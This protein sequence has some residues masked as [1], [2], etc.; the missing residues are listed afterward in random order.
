[1]NI[2]KAVSGY[3]ETT[4]TGTAGEELTK[5]ETTGFE[6]HGAKAR[7]GATAGLGLDINLNNK[8][9]LNIESR[10][11]VT[12]SIFGEGSDCRKA[13][14]TWGFYNLQNLEKMG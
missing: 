9:A 2:S 4:I 5:N 3:C 11:G 13:E 8:W 6:E 1:M 12:P 7:L 14:A 10:F